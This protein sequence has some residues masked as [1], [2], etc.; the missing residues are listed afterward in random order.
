MHRGDYAQ[1]L[2]WSERAAR[3]APRGTPERI[4]ADAYRGVVSLSMV[5]PAA[6]H[7]FLRDAM[8]QAL[9]LG[10]NRVIFAAAGWVFL[11]LQAIRDQERRERLADEVI[12]RPRGGARSG[13]LGM[14]LYSAAQV[15]LA[16]G[17]RARAEA[18]WNELGELAVRT[19]DTT[20][21]TWAKAV[22]VTVAF[23]DGR[24]AEASELA[25]AA[26]ASAREQGISLTWVDTCRLSCLLGRGREQWLE[27]L[28]RPLRGMQC[29]RS[30][31]LANLGRRDEVEEIIERFFGAMGSDD[32]ESSAGIL[33]ALL[34]ACLL[35]QLT[36]PVRLLV[37]RLLPYADRLAMTG[38]SQFGGSGARMLGDG[39]VLLGQPD[40][41]RSYYAQA[42]EVCARVRFRPEIALTRLHLSELLLAQY[43]D[44]QAEAQG[45]LDFAIEEFR[46]MQMK[47][48]LERALRHKGLLHA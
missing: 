21:S 25:D 44:E 30:V 43:P 35:V 13:D 4:Y 47:P 39:A 27:A 7:V 48:A 45:H 29:Y 11:R 3:H 17:E 12:A 26:M 19:R 15:F 20:L 37:R 46:A 16:R 32:D 18:A 2:D 31:V 6:G 14:C 5:S 9:A 24:I 38:G 33:F 41:A 34:E 36:A 1:V 22:P 8:D 42:L 28:D 10:D 40:Q 23:L